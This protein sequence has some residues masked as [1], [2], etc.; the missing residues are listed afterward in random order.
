[1]NKI[2]YLILTTVIAALLAGCTPPAANTNTA[3][4]NSNANAKPAAAPP[5]V[6]A[7]KELETKAFEAWKNHDGKFFEGFLDEKFQMG[8]MGQKIDKAATVKMMSESKCVVNSYSLSDEKMV[9]V[10]ADNAVIVQKLT[11]DATCDG[12]KQP[13]PVISAS[14][15]TRSG[16]AWK[17]VYHNEVPIVDPKAAPA[18]APKPPVVKEVKPANSSTMSA[19]N[20]NSNS[21]LNTAN[22]T[23]NSNSSTSANATASSPGDMTSAW[24]ELEKNGWES[25]RTKDAK[26][27]EDNLA[28]NMVFVDLFGT[29]IPN[30]SDVVKAWTTDN[31]CEIK[32]TSVTEPSSISLGKDAGIFM[33]KGSADGTCEGMPIKPLYGTTV[34]VNEGGIWKAAFII[35]NPV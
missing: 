19:V 28:S 4:V 2:V 23:T 1:M 25:W 9:P 8:G 16:D 14:I 21:A 22:T 29:V 24:Y 12:E 10:G 30:K 17:G 32:S 11:V 13:S 18:T 15:Y 7:L 34:V 3:N 35:E 6:A 20:S 27:Y 33:Y 26:W 31:K 5:T